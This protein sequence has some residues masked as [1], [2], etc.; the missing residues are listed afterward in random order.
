MSYPTR[1]TER[2][3]KVANFLKDNGFFE[4]EELNPEIAHEIAI[5]EFSELFY[6]KWVSGEEEDFK[7]SDG[8]FEDVLKNIIVKTVFESL[9]QKGLIDSIDE[10]N[11]YV[12]EKGKIAL[13]V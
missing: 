12:T 13:K 9:K 10:E 11:H 4:E 6:P 1:V 7:Y 5:N 8:E 3:T 2:A